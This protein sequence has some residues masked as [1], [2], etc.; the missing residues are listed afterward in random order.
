MMR[1]S[2]V[3]LYARRAVNF[4]QVGARKPALPPI[5]TALVPISGLLNVAF[6]MQSLITG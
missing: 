2:I 1:S 6:G 4:T 5:W 3:L